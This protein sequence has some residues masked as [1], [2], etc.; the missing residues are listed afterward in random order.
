MSK[1]QDPDPYKDKKDWSRRH[2]DDCRYC[3]KSDSSTVSRRYLCSWGMLLRR[4]LF[5]RCPMRART[6]EE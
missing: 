1:P 5:D 2:L 3:F 6:G 4:C